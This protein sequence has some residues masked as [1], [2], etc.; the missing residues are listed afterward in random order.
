MKAMMQGIPQLGIGSLQPVVGFRLNGLGF[1]VVD[2][3]EIS[4]LCLVLDCRA[5]PFR[6]EQLQSQP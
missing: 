4:G 3:F 1:R 6:L 5:C 2:S